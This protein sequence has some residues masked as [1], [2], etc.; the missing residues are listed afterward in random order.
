[1]TSRPG[2]WPCQCDRPVRPGLRRPPWT[3]AGP[4]AFKPRG[5][6]SSRSCSHRRRRFHGVAEPHGP[7]AQDRSKLGRP[8][9]EC[10]RRGSCHKLA[11]GTPAGGAAVLRGLRTRHRRA[12]PAGHD[13]R[14]EH[15]A[16]T[17]RG[18]PRPQRRR[19]G[20]LAQ[21]AGL[22]ERD[23]AHHHPGGAGGGTNIESRAGA[24]ALLEGFRGWHGPVRGSV[25]SA[26]TG[27]QRCPA[28]VSSSLRLPRLRGL[29]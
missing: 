25:G 17:P 14:V 3:G 7:G 6:R 29:P 28:D 16:G 23:Q 10:T 5:D 27:Q 1:M 18:L 8:A 9:P 2:P 15:G 24:G 26:G 19:L 20:H 11:R 13:R 4:N 22:P 21:I 12:E